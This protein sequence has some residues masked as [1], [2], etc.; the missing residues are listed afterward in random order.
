MLYVISYDLNSP[1]Q[2]YQPLW[3]AIA[4]IG[5]QRILQS[6]W[7]VNRINTTATGLRDYLWKFMDA[8]DILLVNALGGT[9]WAGYNLIV[10]PNTL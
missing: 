6:Q 10:D 2:N 8:N 4:E 7:V 9:E 1:G 5:G 3:D